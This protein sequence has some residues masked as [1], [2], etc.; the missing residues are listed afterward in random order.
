MDKTKFVS[1]YYIDEKM[2]PIKQLQ[3]I[4]DNRTQDNISRELSEA[5]RKEIAFAFAVI[6]KEL[7]VPIPTDV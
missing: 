3:K 2:Y 1:G 6:A 5:Q 7:D 4:I